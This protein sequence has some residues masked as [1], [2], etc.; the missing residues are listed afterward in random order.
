V[1]EFQILIK[2]LLRLLIFFITKERFMKRYLFVLLAICIAV[3]AFANGG[4]A[5][6]GSAAKT[7][8]GFPNK[9]IEII[10]PYPPASGNDINI[11]T[12]APTL[13]KYLGVPVVVTNEPAGNGLVALTRMGKTIR[14]DGYTWS[15]ANIVATTSQNVLGDLSVDPSTEYAYV[16]VIT[17]DPGLVIAAKNG[18]YKNMADIVNA[19]KTKPG[20]I[21]WGGTG[22][23]S[24][25]GLLCTNLESLAGIDLNLIDTLGGS[26]GITALMGGHLDLMGDSL[27]G[28]LQAYLD[29]SVEILGIGGDSRAPELPNIPT[30]KEQGYD[31]QIQAAERAIIVPAKT[32]KDALDFIRDALKKATDDP[33]YIERCKNVGMRNQYIDPDTTL[34]DVQNLME[35]FKKL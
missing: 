8:S 28:S 35:F 32:D 22:E 30:F 2:A 27:S 23:F 24:L 17:V 5:G 34:R 33:E 1:R 31:F 9:A 13:E 20:Q 18:P 10:V 25:D 16:G 7:S 3:T 19:A 15:Y 29:G 4:A 14:A 11:R 21:S 6:S 12:I 26:V